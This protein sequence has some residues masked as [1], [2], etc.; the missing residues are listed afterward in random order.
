MILL[1]F[2]LFR[3]R[4][5]HTQVSISLI[6]LEFCIMDGFTI[7]NY[8]K[9]I[10]MLSIEQKDAKKKVRVSIDIDGQGTLQVQ[11]KL[12]LKYARSIVHPVSFSFVG[13]IRTTGVCRPGSQSLS[14]P[15]SN[16]T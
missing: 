2:Y 9:N 10:F 6:G 7:K 14:T 8:E 5:P 3:V 13:L 4:S 12:P 16:C 1:N 15:C 11:S